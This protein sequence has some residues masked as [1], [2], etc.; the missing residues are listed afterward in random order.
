MN[1]RPFERPR[2]RSLGV[3]AVSFPRC[4]GALPLR[5][6]GFFRSKGARIT[7]VM[8][9]PRCPQQQQ[10]QQI[11]L[12]LTINGM[13]VV[14]APFARRF[15]RF[16]GPYSTKLALTIN[17]PVMVN[18]TF[19]RRFAHFCKPYSTKLALTINRLVVV[20]A[21]FARSRVFLSPLA[22]FIWLSL[23]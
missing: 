11:F 22:G 3:S 8:G 6:Q 12:A 19:A 13:F 9:A 14:N 17:R 20:N 16:C 15:A 7:A 2:Y 18:G 21:T 4:R 5:G 10:Q 23:L 1:E